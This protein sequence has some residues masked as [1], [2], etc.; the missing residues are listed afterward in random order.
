MVKSRSKSQQLR[1]NPK[2]TTILLLIGSFA[3]INWNNKVKNFF[4]IGIGLIAVVLF[5]CRAPK[6]SAYYQTKSDEAWF[7]EKHRK[8]YKL[9]LKA[10]DVD[11]KNDSLYVRAAYCYQYAFMKNRNKKS[12]DDN[13]RGLYN[14]SLGLKPWN[15]NALLGRAQYDLSHNRYGLVLR[16]MDSL[17]VR[18]KK[19]VSAYWYKAMVL[20]SGG[21]IGDSV[22]YFENFNEGLKNVE[23]KDKPVLYAEI[24]SNYLFAKN[25]ELSK[26]YELKSMAIKKKENTNNLAVCYFKLGQRDSAC[27]YF[28]EK[29]CIG[30]PCVLYKDSLKVKC[31]N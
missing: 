17:L 30:Y 19:N 25:W 26:Y 23:E 6:N 13:I 16:Y 29:D 12:Y 7:K 27:Y 14:K 18:D 31:K 15:A 21:V 20:K 2:L 11:P 28:K 1:F 5:S 24:V 8:A 3:F 4:S 10:I 22:K 9:I